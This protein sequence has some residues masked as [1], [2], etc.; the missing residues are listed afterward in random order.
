MPGCCLLALLMFFGPRVVLACAW[1]LSNWY[2]AF[3]SSLIA[4]AGWLLLPW[5]S[6]AWIY[7]YF[8]NHGALSGG[9]LLVLIVGVALDLGT[10]GGS[11][12]ARM[13]ERE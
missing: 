2:Q 8:H 12:R 11:T 4:F 10:F 1:L 5:T 7:V 6:L 9:Y 3:D 13:A